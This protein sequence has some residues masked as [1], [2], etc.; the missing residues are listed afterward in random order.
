MN[1]LKLLL[2]CMLLAG[3]ASAQSSINGVG[4]QS[5][6]SPPVTLTDAATITTDASKGTRFKVTLGGNRTLAAPT[7]GADGQ[8]YMW[9]FIQDGTG[10]RTLT[11]DPAF[12]FGTDVTGATLSTTAG[13]RDFMGAKYDASTGFWYVLSFAKGY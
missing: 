11:L 7:N 4:N 6:I 3:I 1:S 5:V 12:H 2:G 9:T 8:T 13:K 10:S